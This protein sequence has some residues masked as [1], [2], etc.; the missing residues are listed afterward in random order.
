MVEEKET[1]RREVFKINVGPL[2]KQIL[3]KQKSNVKEVTYGVCPSSDW[4]ASEMIAKKVIEN[5]LV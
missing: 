5:N 2:F 4:E 3:N 1:N